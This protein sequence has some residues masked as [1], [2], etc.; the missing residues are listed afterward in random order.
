M[1]YAIL[2]FDTIICYQLGQLSWYSDCSDW[3][4]DWTAKSV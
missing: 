2:K 1:I 4:T 3:A